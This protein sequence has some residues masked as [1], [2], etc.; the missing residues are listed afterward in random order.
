MNLYVTGL[1]W[2]LG[3]AAAASI[4]TILVHRYSSVE[5]R[6]SNDAVGQVFSIVGGLHAVLMAFVLISLFDT[7][8]TVRD[9]AHTEANSLVAVY[10]ASD[11]LPEPTR[12]QIQELSKSYARIVIDQ[13]WPKMQNGETVP[14]PGWAILDKLRA[15][16]DATQTDGDWQ[17]ARKTEAAS[18]LWNIYQARQA[19]LTAAGSQGVS[20]VVWLALLVGSIL[21]ISLTYLLDVRKLTTHIIIVSTL[22][23]A[24]AL[25]LFAIYQLQNPFSGGAKIGPD[26]FTSVIDRFTSSKA[27]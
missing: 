5:A 2:V 17:S 10:W 14:G 7:V 6:S 26:A 24:I 3:V 8:S 20:T 11:S 12:G 16:I 1:I 19:R 23:S 13:E 22:A 25:L 15:A 9:G 18:Q 27:S 4:G 21:S